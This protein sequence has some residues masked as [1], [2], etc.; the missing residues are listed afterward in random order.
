MIPTRVAHPRL[1]TNT[2]PMMNVAATPS[3]RV[4]TSIP[5]KVK[6]AKTKVTRGEMR[7]IGVTSTAGA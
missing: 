1:R 4:T 6:R 2:P 7:Q 3:L 5:F